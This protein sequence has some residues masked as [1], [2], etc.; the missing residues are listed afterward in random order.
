MLHSFVAAKLLPRLPAW[1]T[2]GQHVASSLVTT[3]FLALHIHEPELETFVDQRNPNLFVI[4]HEKPDAPSNE[5]FT[6][7]HPKAEVDTR[8]LTVMPPLPFQHPLYLSI[9]P[10]IR[11][12]FPRSETYK[13]LMKVEQYQLDQSSL[14]RLLKAVKEA[15]PSIP[16]V[17]ETSDG[18]EP[19]PAW[20]TWSGESPREQPGTLIFR[21][22]VPLSFDLVPFKALPTHLDA[23]VLE[24]VALY[25]Q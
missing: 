23:S 17:R 7:N 14:E 24:Q 2:Y 25:S 4:S 9:T 10:R 22:Y 18:Q 3:P 21:R 16:G 11:G 19:L 12:N 13:K 1:A 8:T 6:L 5:Y 15:G 20:D